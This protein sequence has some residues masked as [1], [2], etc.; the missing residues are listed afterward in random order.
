MFKRTS[1]HLTAGLLLAT[2]ALHAHATEGGI[3]SWPLG[4]ELYGMGI[5]PPPGTYG[6]LFAGNY[7]ADSLRDNSG[8]KAAD[9]DL[10]VTT[11]APRFVWVTEQ[12]VFGGDLGFHALLPLNDMRLNVKGGPH[13]HKRGLGDAH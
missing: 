11:L 8:A 12:K 1:Q 9:I 7:L 6:Q 4:I 5:L 13:D 3:S 2:S 10:R